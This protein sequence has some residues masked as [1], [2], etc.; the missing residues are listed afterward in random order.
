MQL[1][2]PLVRFL[3]VLIILAAGPMVGYGQGGSLSGNEKLYE[4]YVKDREWNRAAIFAM[5]IGEEYQRLG[6]NET[7]LQMFEKAET[8]AIKAKDNRILAQTYERLAGV[9]VA[10]DDKR[11][12]PNFQKALTS[13]ERVGESGAVLRVYL[14]LGR[15]YTKL[16][17]YDRAIQIYEKARALAKA[18]GM[19]KEVLDCYA[20]LAEVYKAK[21]DQANAEAFKEKYAKEAQPEKI[22]TLKEKSESEIA[23]LREQLN[24]PTVARD[25][26]R[27]LDLEKELNEK[28]ASL[29]E[30]N[31]M[32]GNSLDKSQKQNEQQQRLIAAAKERL[33]LYAI[34]AAVV[35][36]LILVGIFSMV[37][38]SR[39]KSALKRSNDEIVK[40]NRLIEAQKE[41][42]QKQ[43]QKTEQLL[44]RKDELL[45]NILPKEVADELEN[46]KNQRYT[47]KHSAVS[48]LFSDFEGF[49]RI[50]GEMDPE[51]LIEELHECFSAFDEICGRHNLE[52]IKTIGDAYMCAGG[53]PKE[54]DTHAVDIVN[55]AL[56]M[57]A[58]MERRKRQREY[59]GHQ[60]LE[61]RIGI[62]TGPLVAGVVGTKKFAYDIWGDTVNTAARMEQS[63]EIGKINL[64]EA[65]YE[66][67]KR[68]F[69]CRYRGQIQAKNKGLIDM[70]FVVEKL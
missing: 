9:Y 43:K 37:R 40:K 64:S 19:E 48:V 45:L 25:T 62:N 7:A 70:Y 50:S 68:D 57:L 55:A 17:E 31:S 15:Y 5:R 61:L 1:L 28:I 51:D 63:G 59:K 4:S 23:K 14:K 42:L 18:K 22:E 69:Y 13:Y 66:L 36:V 3:L 67:V 56:E 16:R 32:L 41:D 33:Q 29:S 54:N 11:A 21:G 30:L 6:D 58:F 53:I 60:P 34:I 49:T 2:L 52:K 12:L 44:V 10:E 8:H 24:D 38:I 27:K 65:T 47:R 39:Q 35:A 26:T 20:R 46:K